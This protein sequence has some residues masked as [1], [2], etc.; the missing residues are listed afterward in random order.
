M[1]IYTR[2]AEIKESKEIENF[3]LELTDRFGA[4]PSATIELL[5]SI[6]LRSLS[7][8]IGCE[9]IILKNKKMIVVFE[10]SNQT[11]AFHDKILKNIINLI[12]IDQDNQFALKENDGKIKLHI[13]NIGNINDSI[14]IIN[15]INA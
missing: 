14:K 2:L 11:N 1:R 15:K 3:K 10:N 12:Q 5:K 4:I 9:K 7:D 13:N 6:S 8:K